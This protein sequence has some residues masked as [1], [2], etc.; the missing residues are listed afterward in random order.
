MDNKSFIIPKEIDEKLRTLEEAL[1][2]C[3]G[4]FRIGESGAMFVDCCGEVTYGS[5]IMGSDIVQCHKCRRAA[6]M[7]LSPHVSPLLINGSTT[8]APTQ[9][10]MDAVG[11]RCWMV[12]PPHGDQL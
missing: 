2:E 6:I 12:S 10:F 8:S 5:G 9:E 7:I 11:E 4:G 3:F 1:T